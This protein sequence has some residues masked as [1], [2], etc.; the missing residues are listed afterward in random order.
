MAVSNIMKLISYYYRQELKHHLLINYIFFNFTLFT[1]TIE[2]KK[3][4]KK[5][6][7]QISKHMILS[8]KKKLARLCIN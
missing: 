6:E 5:K 7:F 8:F 1:S 3:K 2:K 4:K